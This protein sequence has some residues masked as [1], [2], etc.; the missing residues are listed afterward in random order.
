MKDLR[1]ARTPLDPGTKL[2]ISMAPATD[3]EKT[4]AAKFP[5][6]EIIGKVMYLML[7]TRPDIAFAVSFLSKFNSCHGSEH[8]KGVIHLMRY[9]MTTKDMCITY[10]Q[11]PIDLMGFSDASWGADVDTRRSVTGYVFFIA[12]GPISW[13]SKQ[14]TTVA[15]S[16]AEAEYMALCDAAKEAI[17][18]RWLVQDI[19]PIYKSSAKPAI[20][21]EDNTACISAVTHG[22]SPSMRSLLRTHRINIGAMHEFFIDQQAQLSPANGKFSLLYAP[23]ATHKG[24][25]FTK[26][27]APAAFHEALA[28][29]GMRQAG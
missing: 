3:A 13:K 27:L 7:C 22:Y 12:G 10:G 23:T 16:S 21:F 26:A 11:Q 28:R 25:M 15:L 19:S 18:L 2:S 9:L 29:I 8:H 4:A 6:R 20:I 14:Q 17:H 1:Q 5:Y 24:D